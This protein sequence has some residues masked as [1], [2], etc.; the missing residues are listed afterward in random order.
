MSQPANPADPRRCDDRPADATDATDVARADALVAALIDLERHVGGGGWD[1][2]PRLFALVRTDELV[3]AEPALAVELGLRSEDDGAPPEG[4]TGIEQEQ[5]TPTGD[6][7]A[8][9]AEVAWPEAVTGCALSL[10]S[11][12][13]PAGREADLP[14]DPETAAAVVAAHPD[15]VDV[16]LVVGVDRYGHQHGVGRLVSAPEDLLGAPDLVPGLLAALAHTL[17]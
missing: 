2:P 4:L 10:E 13:L 1:Q 14:A 6:V 3:A 8:D 5:F 17:S 15:R 12:F 11:S 16:R 9:L 7:V